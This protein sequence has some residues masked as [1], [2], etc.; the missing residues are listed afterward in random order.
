M[1]RLPILIACGL[2]VALASVPTWA[3]S[4]S[5]S[6]SYFDIGGRT[7][8]D[9]ERELERRGPKLNSTGRRHPGATRMEF[10]TR[11]GYAE[12][13][14]RCAVVSVEVSVSAEMILPRWRSGGADADTR[15]VWSALSADIKRHE[16]SHVEIARNHARMLE[17]T[18]KGLRPGR[19]CE[20]MQARV[21]Q[22][23]DRV[24]EQHD[25]EQERFDR[26]ESRNFESRLRRL[27]DNRARRAGGG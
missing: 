4:L 24:L 1:T 8:P 17:Q 18:L 13:K 11:L 5:K 25:F 15:N 9:I 26:I 12:R 16:E 7:V 10:K 23:T 22:T 6:Y 2:F 3:A 14:G 20:Q 21:Q 19:T 27:I